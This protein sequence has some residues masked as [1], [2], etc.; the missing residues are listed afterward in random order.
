VTDERTP[1]PGPQAAPRTGDPLGEI[2]EEVARIQAEN[3]R[4][5]ERLAEGERRFR[6]ISRGVLRVQEVERGRISRELH[7]G[8][9]QSLTALKM[10][11][12]GL[13]QAGAGEALGGQL[14]ELRELADR[15]LQEVRQI[16][17]LIR[18]Q[19]LDELGLV[20]TLRWLV[21]VLSRRTGIALEFVHEGEEALTDPAAE[22]LVFRV[23]QEALTNVT[24]HSRGARAEVRLRCEPERL[25]LEVRDEGQ[26]F[27]A[28]AALARS[29]E[30]GSFGL[31]GM[32]D[33]VQLLGGRF[34]ISSAPG[35]GTMVRVELPLEPS[36]GGRG[37]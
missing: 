37:R 7:D 5:L 33:R 1:L 28:A 21:R 15:C 32:R 24:K 16:S 13:E 19:I 35:A 23:V 20:P 14:G 2:A 18:P 34:E 8:V 31:R 30:E 17:H 25:R 22:T 4:L 26:G 9:G 27:D 12:E 10:Q 3:A 36:P 29:D 11:I 6:H